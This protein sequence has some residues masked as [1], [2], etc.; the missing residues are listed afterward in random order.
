MKTIDTYGSFED[1]MSG[2]NDLVK[3]IADQ[4][5]QLILEVY[6]EAIE[7]PWPKQH[8]ASYG[9][10]PKK[11]TEHFCYIGVQRHYVNLGFYYGAQLSDPEQLLE[12]TGNNLRHI[13]IKTVDDVDRPAIR[14]MIEQSLAERQQTLN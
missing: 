4:L 9:V 10:G 6:P 1:A 11:M 13:K 7:L 8:I 14:Q 12:G 2:A 5:R 3:A